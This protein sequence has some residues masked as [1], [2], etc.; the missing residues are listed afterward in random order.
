M[1][2]VVSRRVG[3]RDS[4]RSISWIVDHHTALVEND[5]L[6]ILLLLVWSL[7][8]KVSWS[9]VVRTACRVVRLG[10][11]QVLL[12]AIVEGHGLGKLVLVLGRGRA[13]AGWVSS[14]GHLFLFSI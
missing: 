2:H 12:T 3:G 4:D 7:L 6:D 8:L 14:H 1:V 11:V 9:G 10:Q 5:L 13:G